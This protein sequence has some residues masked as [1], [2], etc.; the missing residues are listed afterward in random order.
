MGEEL[1]EGEVGAEVGRLGEGLN[2]RG[3]EELCEEEGVRVRGRAGYEVGC[4]AR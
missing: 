2:L 3:F 4:G 1:E